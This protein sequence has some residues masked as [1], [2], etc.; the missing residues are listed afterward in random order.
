MIATLLRDVCW[1]KAHW[2]HEL[3]DMMQVRDSRHCLVTC[4]AHMQIADRDAHMHQGACG[5]IYIILRWAF[6]CQ[7]TEIW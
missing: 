4:M 2:M 3:P 5:A 6:I 1:L 7:A